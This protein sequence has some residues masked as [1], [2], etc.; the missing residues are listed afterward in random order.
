MLRGLIKVAQ[1]LDSLGLTKDANELDGIIRKLASDEDAKAEF[2]AAQEEAK[3][4]SAELREANR[5]DF[6]SKPQ[7]TEAEQVALDAKRWRE[8]QVMEAEDP[9]AK[10]T[11]R[12]VI[13]AKRFARM[14][15]LLFLTKK[16][17]GLDHEDTKRLQS[18]LADQKIIL[19]GILDDAAKIGKMCRYNIFKTIQETLT[20]PIT[21]R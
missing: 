19:D 4:R 5:P 3:R 17:S 1:K 9:E 13:E 16:Q 6:H 7:L 11:D 21:H 18:K 14:K 2:Y 15:H 10:L 12:A 8:Q 20:A